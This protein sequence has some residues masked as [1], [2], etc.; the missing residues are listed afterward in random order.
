MKR[1]RGEPNTKI[2]LTIAR[3]NEDK[4]VVVSL[5]REL[6]KQHS[7]KAKVIEPGYAWLRISQFQE[8][9]VEEMAKRFKACMRKIHS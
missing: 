6:I 8:P 4:P 1:L 9:T 2:T 5:V 7:V 3:K